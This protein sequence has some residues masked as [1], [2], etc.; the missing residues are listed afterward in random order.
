MTADAGAALPVATHSRGAL[1]SVTVVPRASRTVME[2]LPD[3]TLRVR[4]AAP[5]VDGAANTALLRYLA[6]A[7]N[8]PR[9][10]LTISS[11]ATSRRKRIAIEGVSDTE[12]VDRVWGA[13]G[14]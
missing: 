7:L 10:R 12:L 2:R 8:L 3:G 9:S 4:L 1:L 6:D 13:L 11:G 5:P 14:R